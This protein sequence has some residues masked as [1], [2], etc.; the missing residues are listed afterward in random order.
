MESGSGF[1]RLVVGGSPSLD[2]VDSFT[3]TG[4]IGVLSRT[5]GLAAD[6][7][8]SAQVVLADGRIAAVNAGSVTVTDSKGTQTVKMFSLELEALQVV[9]CH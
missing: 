8:V 5:Y 7:L 3:Q 6:N 9:Q 4:G 1:S 2:T